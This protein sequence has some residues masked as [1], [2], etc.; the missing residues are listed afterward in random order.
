MSIQNCV[1][2]TMNLVHTDRYYSNPIIIVLFS[3]SF[4]SNNNYGSGLQKQKLGFSVWFIYNTRTYNEFER[5]IP[6][7]NSTLSL[8]LCTIHQNFNVSPNLIWIKIKNYF[9]FIFT[10]KNCIFKQ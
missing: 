5:N 1:S 6:E 9:I 8:Y 2:I 4:L 3:K 7:I 10:H